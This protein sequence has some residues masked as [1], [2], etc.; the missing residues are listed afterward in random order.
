VFLQHILHAVEVD[1]FQITAGRHRGGEPAVHQ[2]QQVAA[3]PAAIRMAPKQLVA[4][5][6]DR[7][8]LFASVIASTTERAVDP[9]V[10]SRSSLHIKFDTAFASGLFETCFLL[11]GVY[12]ETVHTLIAFME[13]G[14]LPLFSNK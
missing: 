3:K 13:A 8:F 5:G 2:L 1:S 6:A 12:V 9:N 7:D 4:F 10:R 11:G 14:M